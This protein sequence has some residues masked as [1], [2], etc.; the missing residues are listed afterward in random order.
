[1]LPNERRIT[2]RAGLRMLRRARSTQILNSRQGLRVL[3]QGLALRG[4]SP[5]L[6][7]STAA[8]GFEYCDSLLRGLG[9]QFDLPS[10][11]AQGFEYCDSL[12]RG[13]GVQFELP[14]T[15]AQGVEYSDPLLR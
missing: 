12:L 15:A 14:S 7:L 1:M 13:L 5:P 9:V 8:Q 11:A 3:G 6:P 4:A 2:G 10:T